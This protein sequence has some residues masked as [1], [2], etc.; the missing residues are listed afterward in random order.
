VKAV[1]LLE[2]ELEFGRGGRHIDPR[3]GIAFY[4]PADL[5][6]TVKQVRVA[7]IGPQAHIDGIKAWLESCRKR[8]DGKD[9]HLRY[10]HQPFPG[11]SPDS[12]FAATV[13]FNSRLERTLGK[14][15][16]SALSGLKPLAALTAAVELY[17]RELAILAEEAQVDVVLVCRPEEL[18]D[19]LPATDES[20]GDANSD[21]GAQGDTPAG[22]APRVTTGASRQVMPMPTGM[23]FHSMLKARALRYGKPIQILRRGTWDS[24]FK[25]KTRSGTARARQDPATRAWNLHTALYYKA[26]KIPWRLPR[27]NRDY[28]TLYV[29]ATFYRTIGDEALRTSVAQVFNERGDGVIVRGAKA[30][31]AKTDRQPHLS[32]DGAYELL[33]SALNN[34]HREHR[35]L[36]ARVVMHKSSDY[37]ESELHGFRAAAEEYRLT[38]LELLW[39]SNS[40]ARLFRPGEFPPLRC[41]MLSLTDTRHVLYTRGAV[42]AYQTYPGMYVPTALAFR[43]VDTETSAGELATEILA[44]S[45]MNWNAT[46]LDG[47]LPITVRTAKSVGD[48]L[49]HVPFD[50]SPA[51]R[52]AFYM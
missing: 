36:P 13:V 51:G 41:T 31:V 5:D 10:L 37:T 18:D 23:D 1:V 21:A 11:F 33:S 39:L 45:K 28:T 8:I 15:E 27:R 30:K 42:P 49:R 25:D 50:Q 35:T 44:L 6:G 22:G 12:P 38:M 14:R 52:Y 29:G 40:P 3:Q 43:M 16:L 4:G 20:D 7:I 24:A 17:D 32:E 34:Y 47:R 2:P 19:S 9:S 26:G 48:I 46:P